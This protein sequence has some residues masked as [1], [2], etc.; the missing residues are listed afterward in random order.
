MANMPKVITLILA[1][2]GVAVLCLAA[3][4]ASR[5]PPTSTVYYHF[6]G[7]EFIA[8]LPPGGGPYLAVG[9]RLLPEVLSG[10]AKSAAVGLAS[11]KGA[12]A[13]ICYIQHSGGKLGGGPGYT[14]C[15]RMALRI[16][17]GETALAT[18]TTD[19]DGYFVALLD[20]GKYRIGDRPLSVEVEVKEGQTTLVPLRAGK[21]MVD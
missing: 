4:S 11:G 6:N 14:P 19:G 12:I 10:A 17:S 15:S 18:V 3:Q 2:M 13:G 7:K 5:R 1:G 9:E 16:S 21:R 20:P 8:G